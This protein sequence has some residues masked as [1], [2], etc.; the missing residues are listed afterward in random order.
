M[1]K[2]NARKKSTESNAGRENHQIIDFL[3]LPITVLYFQRYFRIAI[4]FQDIK[5]MLKIT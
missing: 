1:Q 2:S 3:R 5:C 4:N